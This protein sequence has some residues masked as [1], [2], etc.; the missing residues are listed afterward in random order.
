MIGGMNKKK[1]SL[2]P[3]HSLQS[4]MVQESYKFSDDMKV[5]ICYKRTCH[6]H[7]IDKASLRYGLLDV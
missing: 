2:N 5:L 3:N 7:N 4:V 6:T 1:S